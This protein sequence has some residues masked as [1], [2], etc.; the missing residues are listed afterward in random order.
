[1]KRAPWIILFT[2][3]IIAAALSACDLS[4]LTLPTLTLPTT[5]ATNGLYIPRSLVHDPFENNSFV[6]IAPIIDEGEIL[7]SGSLDCP[8]MKI[9]LKGNEDNLY[10]VIL[11]VSWISTNHLDL[12]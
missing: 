7:V 5:E 4:T 10:S 6:F 1:M 8:R 11:F 2:S 9:G 12:G 3:V